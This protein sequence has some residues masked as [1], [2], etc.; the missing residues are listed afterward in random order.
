MVKVGRLL[1]E[2]FDCFFNKKIDNLII[3]SQIGPIANRMKMLQGMIIQ[4]FILKYKML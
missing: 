4:Y 3:E 2:K 1:K